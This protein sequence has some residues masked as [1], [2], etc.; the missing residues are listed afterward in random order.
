[1][2]AISKTQRAVPYEPAASAGFEGMR[3]QQAVLPVIE[4]AGEQ[5]WTDFCRSLK[6][7]AF[8][9]ADSDVVELEQT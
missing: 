8:L 1:M 4:S 7:P 5:S 3:A 9:L 2:T 6:R